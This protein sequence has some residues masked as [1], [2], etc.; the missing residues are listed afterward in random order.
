MASLFSAQAAS[1]SA[2]AHAA[3]VAQC[4]AT[5]PNFDAQRATVLEMKEY[6]GCVETLYP[7]EIDAAQRW[8]EPRRTAPVTANALA[9]AD[10]ACGGSPGAM[11]WA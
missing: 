10:A 3:R 4:K 1:A 11:G 9:Q 5:I 6:A 8:P 2:A 7:T